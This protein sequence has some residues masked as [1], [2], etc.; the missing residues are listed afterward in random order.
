MRFIRQSKMICILLIFLLAFN[1]MNMLLIA[2]DRIPITEGFLPAVNDTHDEWEA[3]VFAPEDVLPVPVPDLLSLLD[4]SE[5]MSLSAFD[6][7]LQEAGIVFAPEGLLP[8]PDAVPVLM[9]DISTSEMMLPV[10]VPEHIFQAALQ[11][12]VMDLN[13]ITFS[14]EGVFPS[15][16]EI[17]YESTLNT[18]TDVVLP[19][20]IEGFVIYPG[21]VLF[22]TGI[23]F[24]PE[25]LLPVPDNILSESTPESVLQLPRP[26]PYIEFDPFVSVTTVNDYEPFAP[27]GV[28]PMPSGGFAVYGMESVEADSIAPASI[29]IINYR[30]NGHTGGMVPPSH[31][32]AIGSIVTLRQPGTMIRTGHVFIG[33]RDISGNIFQAGFSWQSSWPIYDFD[34]VWAPITDVHFIGNGHTH[35]TVPPMIRQQIPSWITLPPPG[36][37]ARTGYTFGG[38]RCW[39][40]GLNPVGT[41]W[42]QSY[43]GGFVFYAEWIPNAAAIQIHYRG[44]GHTSGN[45]PPVQQHIAP[46]TITL[47]HPGNM[48]NSGHIFGGWRDSWGNVRPAGFTWTQFT[49]G[50]FTFDAVWLP[51][52]D[53]FLNGNGHTHGTVPPMI[54]QQV[55]SW[56]TLPPPGTMARTGYTFGGWRCWSGALHPVGTSWWQAGIGGFAFYAEWVPERRATIIYRGNGHT[57]GTVPATQNVAVPAYLTLSQP[58]NMTR[59][60]GY[61][62]IGWSD[63]RGGLFPAGFRWHDTNGGT[64]FFDAVWVPIADVSFNGN[65][66]THGTV[67]PMIRQQVPSLITLPP[68]GNMTRTGHT[69]G[70]WRCWSGTLHPVGTSWWQEGIGGFLYYAEWI[71]NAATIQINYRG[72][73]HTHGTVPQAQSHAAPR[74]IT[75]SHP[76][77]MSRTGHIFAGWRDASGN[78]R[79]AGFTWTQSGGGTFTFDAVWIPI[80]EV[81][82]NGNGNTH[83]NPPPMIRQPVPSTITLPPPGNMTRTGHTFGGWRCWSGALHPVGTSWWQSGIGGFAFY[84]EWVPIT[85]TPPGT[86]TIVYRSHGHTGGNVPA[87][88]MHN[89]PATITLSG[90]GNMTG[91]QS[92]RLGG[93]SNRLGG[94]AAWDGHTLYQGGIMPDDIHVFDPSSNLVR[95]GY[96]FRGWRDSRGNLLQ[97]GHTWMQR[98]DAVI[99]LDAVWQ[100]NCCDM[101]SFVF[102]LPQGDRTRCYCNGNNMAGC[103]WFKRWRHQQCTNCLYM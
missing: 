33:W 15:P 87:P 61:I 12:N 47:S 27:A 57:H 53:V 62:F 30:G 51:I 82:L 73:G 72:N 31:S 8:A 71:P 66:H 74:T 10:P 96:V 81:H 56:I 28:V 5:T 14:P 29:A 37:M 19:V 39:T 9:P 7:I 100:R 79:Q 17:L 99:Y 103:E 35:G 55:P 93:E 4:A 90:P 67:P 77:N 36:T 86:V 34:A 75:L 46:R 49:S 3:L 95:P 80:A 52:T 54:R 32:H 38:W 68:P 16:I 22:D 65:G 59:A 18:T 23:N 41:S 1:S 101:P 63:G 2:E 13:G 102:V 42:W 89:V 91:G 78:V 92:N 85:S 70:G 20:P 45:V 84:A 48:A 69:F 44:N 64:F 21:D 76:G 98:P 97:A 58:G 40:G 24:A 26:F 88:Q 60:G 50:S 6:Q 11:D 94:A 25:Y 83:G 43:I